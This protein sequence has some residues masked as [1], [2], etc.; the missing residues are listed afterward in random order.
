MAKSV[1]LLHRLSESADVTLP[2]WDAEQAAQEGD[3]DRWVAELLAALA[4]TGRQA[5][6]D[7]E[8]AGLAAERAVLE[9]DDARRRAEQHAR[10]DVAR[11]DSLWLGEHAEQIAAASTRFEAAQRAEVVLPLAAQAARASR[12]A[13]QSARAATRA[14]AAVGSELEHDVPDDP[15][16][17]DVDA[18]AEQLGERARLATA[19]AAVASDFLPGP[20]S[21]N[22][23]PWH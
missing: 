9:H 16:G 21:C 2:D 14:V 17:D 15:S 1:A 18:L 23:R 6:Q 10:H 12:A 19:R 4:S 7:L 13:E 20:R 5:D 3:L 11:Q 22:A 8:S